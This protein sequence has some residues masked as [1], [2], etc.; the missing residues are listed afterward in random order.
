[1]KVEYVFPIRSPIGVPERLTHE[2]V[3]V[4]SELQ[5]RPPAVEDARTMGHLL[6]EDVVTE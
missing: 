5:R 3:R 6:R 2:V 4:N 1:M